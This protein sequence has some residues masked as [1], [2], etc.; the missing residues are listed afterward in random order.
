MSGYVEERANN[1]VTLF[2][3]TGLYL[4]LIN[5]NGKFDHVITTKSLEDIEESLNKMRE[6][7]EDTSSP[8]G[9]FFGKI[10]LSGG[11]IKTNNLMRF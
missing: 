3:L 10:S 9:G 11:N 5:L 1:Y 8:R 2:G 4:L 7:I 6:T